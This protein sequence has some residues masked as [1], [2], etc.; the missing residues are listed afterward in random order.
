MMLAE[1][2]SGPRGNPRLDNCLDRSLIAYRFLSKAGA[3]PELVVGVAKPGE[4]VRGHA[5]VRLDGVALRETDESLDGFEELA[6]FGGAG[7]LTRGA[8]YAD[9]ATT[10]SRPDLWR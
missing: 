2:L 10:P 4:E 5:W 3:A 8:P 6:S 9:P 7:A 1:T